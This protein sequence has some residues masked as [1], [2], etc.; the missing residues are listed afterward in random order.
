MRAERS[1]RKKLKATCVHI[2]ALSCVGGGNGGGTVQRTSKLFSLERLSLS[3][4]FSIRSSIILE[5]AVCCNQAADLPQLLREQP[6]P[7]PV[8]ATAGPAQSQMGTLISF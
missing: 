4:R 3:S 8:Y 6:P 2:N 1:A 5:S 7:P